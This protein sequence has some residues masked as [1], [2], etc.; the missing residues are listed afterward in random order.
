LKLAPGSYDEYSDLHRICVKMSDAHFQNKNFEQA[1]EVLNPASNALQ[2]GGGHIYKWRAKALFALN[3]FEES[4]TDLNT[5][6]DRTPSDASALVWIGMEQIAD[7]S[8]D[9][10]RNG[11]RMLSDR[12]VALN[13]VSAGSL[14]Q[15]AQVLLALDDQQQAREDLDAAV[16]TDEAPFHIWYWAALLAAASDDA[17]RYQELCRQM[18]A[19]FESSEIAVELHFAAWTCA[20]H[21]RATDD[22]ELA[23]KPGQLA[24]DAD[25]AN[26][27][28]VIGM[29][30]V[31]LRAG[32]YAKALESLAAAAG[33]DESSNTPN[34]YSVYFRS[35]TEYRLDRHQDAI[36][37]L[38]HG[39]RAL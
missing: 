38:T 21:P 20:L 8:D 31:Q 35:M 36:A 2:A 5:C 3:R 28:F 25:P 18:L 33:K 23:S 29:G 16:A 27:Q 10:F 34:A 37:S 24:V 32:E 15:R 13:D 26:Q 4:L 22:Y 30:A 39:Q 19:K 14:V 6:L 7:C 12:E 17:A 11:L 9:A 1:I